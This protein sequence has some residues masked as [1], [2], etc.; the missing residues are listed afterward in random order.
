ML[1][2]HLLLLL[3]YSTGKGNEV[4]YSENRGIKLLFCSFS[5]SVIFRKLASFLEIII[6]L[7]LIVF[8]I[9]NTKGKLCSHN[10]EKTKT[11]RISLTKRIMNYIETLTVILM[12]QWT[13]FLSLNQLKVFWNVKWAE[14]YFYIHL[15]DYSFVFSTFL[16][17]RYR[18]VLFHVIELGKRHRE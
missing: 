1:L 18:K 10:S 17:A 8:Q 5:Y 14:F 9:R 16:A 7:F 12:F 4:N 6:F 2:Y 3:R 13:V 11:K 15:T